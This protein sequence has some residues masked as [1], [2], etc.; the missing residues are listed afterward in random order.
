ME[1]FI[2]AGNTEEQ[3]AWL[4][5]RQTKGDDASQE[6]VDLWKTTWKFKYYKK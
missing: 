1:E 3:W 2:E 6:Y 5:F 4:N